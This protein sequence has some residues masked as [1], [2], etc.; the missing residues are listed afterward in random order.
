MGFNKVPT[1]IFKFVHL[2]MLNIKTKL[3]P[4]YKT[5]SNTGTLVILAWVCL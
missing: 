1:F 3:M 2:D 4:N 5:H